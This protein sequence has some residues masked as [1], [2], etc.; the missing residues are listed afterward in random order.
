MGKKLTLEEIKERLKEINPNVEILNDKYIGNFTK[1][2]CKCLIDSHEWEVTWDNLSHNRGC[3]VCSGRALHDGNRLSLLRPDLVK[4]FPNPNDADNY[5]VSSNKKVQLKCPECGM[6][7]TKQMKISK[8]SNLRFSC[9]YCSDGISLPEKFGINL[10]R[11][12]NIEFETQKVFDWSKDRKYDKY[13]R[14]NDEEFLCEI[15]GLQHF[16]ETTRGRSL[17]EEQGNDLLKYNTAIKNGIKPENY[18]IIDARHS[19]LE[20]LKNSFTKQLSYIVD[21]SIVDWVKVFESSQESLV[22]KVWDYWNNK[23]EDDTTLTIAKQLELSRSTIIRY[24]KRGNEIGKC[25][26]DAREENRKR[27]VKVG[28]NSAKTVYQYTLE[29]EFIQQFKSGFEAESQL[30]IKQ[31]SISS[32][33]NGKYKSAGGFK[34]AYNPP[35]M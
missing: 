35:I 23:N 13:F 9:D 5:T 25:F 6:L 20:W 31:S 15:Q 26:Y 29:D 7:K 24:L 34:W 30:N 22:I 18:I 33:C 10:F 8:L 17:R 21:L 14:L 1:L 4:Y 16:K 11:Q 28:K 19:E 3:P 32:C 2:K 12:L 27:G